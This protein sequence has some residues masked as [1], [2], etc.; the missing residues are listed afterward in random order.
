M[1]NALFRIGIDSSILTK[2]FLPDINIKF[3]ELQKDFLKYK[4]KG[5]KKGHIKNIFKRF[6][7][8]FFIESVVVFRNKIIHTGMLVDNSED[9]K[10]ILNRIYKRSKKEYNGEKACI[11]E[12]VYNFVLI[13][14][15]RYDLSSEDQF[16]AFE[17]IVNLILLTVLDSDCE[18]D[19]S[20]FLG[21]N[22]EFFKP[23]AQDYVKQFLKC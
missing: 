4:S 8:E 23:S 18:L 22:K 19:K 14:F 9:I 13:K 20:K 21:Q 15:Q 6:K 10:E 7:N 17:A 11:L 3:D 2:I 1:N 12:K 5:M 16:W